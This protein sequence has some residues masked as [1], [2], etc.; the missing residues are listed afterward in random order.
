[1]L[2]LNNERADG[3]LFFLSV[4]NQ[5][6]VDAGTQDSYVAG[7]SGK[8][9]GPTQEYILLPLQP[10]RTR[11]PVKDVVQDAQAQPSESASPDKDIQDSKDVI[12]NEGQHQMPEDEEVWQDELEMMIGDAVLIINNMDITI[13]VS[14]IP[15]LI[16]INRTNHNDYQ[17]LFVRIFSLSRRTQDKSQALKDGKLG[18]LVYQMD[19][20]SAFLYGKIK[21]EVYVHQLPG[22]VDPTHPNKVYKVVKALYGLHQAPR[23]WF[24]V[25]PK[26]SHLHAVKRIFRYLKHQPKLGLWY[27]R[28]SPFELK[29]FSDSDYAGASLDRKSTTGDV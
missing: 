12:D 19:V 2:P 13:A 4:K 28:D 10:Y 18:F 27:P 14:P 24:Q 9:T 23:A 25:T 26:A 15:I 8:D 29:A 20:K 22:F 6:N 3:A 21:Q 1:M 16:I 5:I 11:F 7:S 17:E